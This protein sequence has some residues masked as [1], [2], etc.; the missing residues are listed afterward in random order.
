MDQ[1]ILESLAEVQGRPIFL[2]LNKSDQH[3]A[4]ELE[5]EL[6]FYSETGLF[7]ESFTLSAKT[8]QGMEEVKERIYAA[9]PEGPQY[10]PE[11]MITDRTERFLIS[12]IVRE[13][14]LEVLREEIPHGIYVQVDEM[15]ER[16]QGN[17]YDIY[18]TI[19]CEKESH[20]G[21]VIGKGGQMLKE[22]GSLARKEIEDLL[23]ARV[24]LKLWVKVDKNWRKKQGKIKRLG[25]D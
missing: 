25:F 1:R 7:A 21:M 20:K 2:L 5:K 18:L 24:N 15:Q 14:C 19:Y 22:I 11:E 23:D 3:P 16:P 12:E 6:A 17:F 10:F 9:L 8:G 13:K 4:E